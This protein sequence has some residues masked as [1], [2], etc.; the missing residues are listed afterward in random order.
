M[1]NPFGQEKT[2]TMIFNE[3]QLEEVAESNS[4]ITSTNK[5]STIM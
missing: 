4:E 2:K 3:S 1:T 5:G